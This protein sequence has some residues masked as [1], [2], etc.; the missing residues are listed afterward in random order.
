MKQNALWFLET[1][2]DFFFGFAIF[3]ALISCSVGYSS[4]LDEAG[5]Y[6]ALLITTAFN[7][8]QTLM[9]WAGFHVLLDWYETAKETKE[10]LK[11]KEE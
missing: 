7:I 1:F 10:L 8:F 5:A 2:G 3:Y 6:L 11:K 9:I 4:V